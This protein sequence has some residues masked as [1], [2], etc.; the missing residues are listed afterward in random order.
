MFSIVGECLL[1]HGS[2]LEFLI[3][4]PLGLGLK[5]HLILLVARQ[6]DMVES[7]QAIQVA[8][9]LIEDLVIKVLLI[10]SSLQC[11]SCSS[12]VRGPYFMR[13]ILEKLLALV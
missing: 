12:L 3:S 9:R 6:L 7:R 4:H 11:N 10:Q 13:M 2:S 5:C 1:I 8:D